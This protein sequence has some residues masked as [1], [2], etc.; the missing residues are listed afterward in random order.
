[1]RWPARIRAF[2]ASVAAGQQ[3]KDQLREAIEVI[4]G[5]AAREEGLGSI[6]QITTYVH[7]GWTK[8]ASGVW[9]Y[10]HTAGAVGA[11]GLITDVSVRLPVELSD[12]RL[13]APPEGDRLIEAVRA[14]LGLLELGPDRLMVPTLGAAYR[15]VLGP[16]DFALHSFGASDAFKTEVAKLALAHQC[17]C[18]NS[19]DLKPIE[20]SSTGNS[21]EGLLHIAKD[22][23]AVVDDL[24][25]GGLNRREREA[26]MSTASRVLRS[27]GNQG[28]RSR[29]TRDSSLQSLKAPRGL[30]C[31]TGEELP[32][33]LSGIARAWLIE[34]HQGDVTSAALTAAQGAAPLYSQAMSGYVRWLA[35]RIADMP[36]RIR[37][38]RESIRATYP[39]SHRRTSEIAFHLEL[40]WNVWLQF[41]VACGA[42]NDQRAAEIL[43]RVRAALLEGCHDQVEEQGKVNPIELY[44]NGLHAAIS[45]GKV[46]VEGP[47]GGFPPDPG[48]WGW[49]SSEYFAD[50]GMDSHQATKVVKT[51]WD[52]AN[53]Q[54]KI[55][56]LDQDNLYLL[57]EVAYNAASAQLHDGLGIDEKALRLRLRDAGALKSVGDGK[58]VPKKAPRA[59]DSSQP[60]V[61]HFRRSFL[62]GSGPS[63]DPTVPDA[64]PDPQSR[65][66]ITLNSETGGSAR[67]NRP[68]ERPE[69]P[70]DPTYPTDPGEGR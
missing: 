63:A 10:L 31:S 44:R 54:G 18:Q 19:R 32:R 27:Q 38:K 56:W 62:V 7:T 45:S 17:Q 65:S 70:P 8:A 21:V 57:P 13:P 42:I 28:G 39:A 1:M 47:N 24:L 4:S 9:I 6:R 60:R 26:M 30:I 36:T 67:S 20:W 3:V 41:A 46:Y 33:G 53:R 15:S 35:S 55:G 22:V 23:L 51:R 58:N 14:S 49:V 40:G 43:A 5:E 12:Y 69:R 29:M 16:A 2:D 48:A 68:S 34:Q 37:E 52:P 11:A 59:I 64:D 66:R 61:L 50:D 25:P